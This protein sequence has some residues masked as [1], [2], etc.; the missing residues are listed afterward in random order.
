MSPMRSATPATSPER[1]T[2]GLRMLWS[3]HS[4]RDI[5][6]GF[7]FEPNQLRLPAHQTLI[8]D[9]QN[10]ARYPKINVFRRLH[11]HGGRA[12]CD[13]PGPRPDRDDRRGRVRH[14]DAG[15]FAKADARGA[16]PSRRDRATAPS[17]L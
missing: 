14:P 9:G 5:S 15:C 6:I 12:G 4:V 1:K 11:H 8:E 3:W 16:N 7:K 10:L 2:S 13:R 17:E